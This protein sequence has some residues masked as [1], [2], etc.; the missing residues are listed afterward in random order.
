VNLT[1]YGAIRGT[2][3]TGLTPIRLDGE[4]VGSDRL[5]GVQAEI[6]GYGTHSWRK[7]TLGLDYRG[8]Y[9]RVS[10]RLGYNGFNQVISLD[11][12][13]VP[14]PRKQFF[15]RES[16]GTLNRGF[17]GFAAPATS[18][19]SDINLVNNELF[20][21]RSYFSQTNAGF[22]MRTSA[23]LAYTFTGDYFFTK[24]PDPRLVGAAGYGG[25]AS[26]E[27]RFSARSAISVD[28]QHL[29]FQFRR[30]Y[31]NSD[32]DGS[33][34]AYSR[35]VNRNLNVSVFGGMMRV[36][37]IGTQQ[38][39]LSEEVAAI[40]GRSRGVA[41]FSRTD[42]VPQGGA[43]ASYA[44]ER[45]RFTAQYMSAVTP[46]NGVYLTS[47]MQ[48]ASVGYSFTGIRR[49]SLGVSSRYAKMKSLSIST[50]GD[51]NTIG[52]G[53]GLNYALTGLLSL[54]TQ[55]DY[56]SFRTGGIAGREGYFLG[57]GLAVSGARVPLSI[58]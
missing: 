15:V 32:I 1:A 25:G 57:V 9:R 46:G 5:T 43:T 7:T 19:R 49:L 35:Q 13:Y 11:L 20:D 26:V 12:T 58:W 44:W 52:G 41:S 8:D 47:Q 27:Y 53:G 51:Q 56:R 37:T 24:R 21:A 17:G 3:E 54:S 28:Y 36:H 30:A 18:S 16:G 2:V 31:G 40:L 14:S 10:Q 6:G 34:V 50:I 33:A 42:W 39:E 55:F 22:V 38:V 23:R 29:Q 4:Q 48:E 45:S